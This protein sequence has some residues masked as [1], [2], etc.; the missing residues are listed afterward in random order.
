MSIQKKNTLQSD[1]HIPVLTQEVVTALALIDNGIYV[2]ATFGGGGHTRAILEANKSCT[3]ISFDWD[4]EALEFNSKAL[5]EEFGERFIPV[6]GSFAHLHRHLKKLKIKKINGM[7]ADLGTSQHQLHEEAG[8]SFHHDTPLDMRMSA[9]HHFHT[10]AHILN[11][12]SEKDLADLIYYY[13]EDHRSRKIAR[14]LVEMRAQ[15]PFKTTRDLAKLMEEKFPTPGKRIHTATKIFQALRIE[16]NKEFDNINSLLLSTLEYLA[17]GG[18]MAVISFHSLED[19][20]IKQFY[21]NHK[22]KLTIIT[23]KPITASEEELEK[24]RSSRSAKLRVAEKVL[25]IYG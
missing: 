16:V 12:Y 14:A 1:Y 15:K 6:W 19:R 5:E 10:A 9:A 21:N 25:S 22:N 2:D 17:P 24:N 23:R 4:Q 13:G 7:L 20:L 18:R 3:V 11:H 8:F